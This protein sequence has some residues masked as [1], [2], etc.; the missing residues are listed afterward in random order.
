MDTTTI[1]SLLT[2][3]LGALAAIGSFVAGYAALKSSSLSQRSNDATIYMNMMNTYSSPE[4]KEA[5]RIIGDA[6]RMHGDEFPSMWRTAFKNREEEALKIDD[7]RTKIK[8]FYRT[9]AQ[10]HIQNLISFDLVKAVCKAQ[11]SKLLISPIE[12]MEHLVNEDYNR[13]T[14]Q[15][16]KKARDENKKD[17][18][19]D[20]SGY[21]SQ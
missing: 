14:Y 10:L 6:K 13:E 15:I 4:F 3:A 17:G 11:G 12:R 19:N 18:Y 20:P 2:I 9:L 1:I 8:Y 16:I 5:L 7:A 21:P